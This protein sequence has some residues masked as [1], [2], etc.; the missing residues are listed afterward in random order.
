MWQSFEARIPCAH[1]QDDLAR[2]AFTCAENLSSTLPHPFRQTLVT[3][4]IQRCRI[5]RIC[6]RVSTLLDEIYTYKILMARFLTS[7]CF[8]L[9]LK[10]ANSLCC[11]KPGF[12]IDYVFT[13]PLLSVYI[14]IIIVI[15]MM[16]PL[17]VAD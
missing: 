14:F 11:M 7:F 13:L 5:P 9:G 3:W 8:K 4:A 12:G 10:W 15:I 17:S 2:F 1:E 6:R 16:S